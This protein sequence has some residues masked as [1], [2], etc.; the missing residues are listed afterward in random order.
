MGVSEPKK[1]LTKEQIIEILRRN[2][3]LF[4]NE[5]EFIAYIV[6]LAMYLLENFLNRCRKKALPR[7]RSKPRPRKSKTFTGCSSVSRPDR[8]RRASAPCAVV[9]S[10]ASASAPIAMR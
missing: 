7:P 1:T 2:A 4:K 8:H 3:R 6:D 10:K 5:P 9:P